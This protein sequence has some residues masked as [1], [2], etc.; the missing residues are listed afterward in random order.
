VRELLNW[1]HGDVEWIDVVGG[2]LTLAADDAWNLEQIEQVV[3]VIRLHRPTNERLHRRH[4]ART[5]VRYLSPP[6]IIIIIVMFV[7]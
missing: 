6:N 4:A 7:Y 1:T 2:A 5:E 3:A